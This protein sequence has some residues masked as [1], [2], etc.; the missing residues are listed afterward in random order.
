MMRRTT[1][2][3]LAALA[4]VAPGAAAQ[5][6]ASQSKEPETDGRPLSAW[7][8]DLK[9]D[10]PQVRNA[11][12]YE[13]SGLGPAAV[14]AVPALIEALNDPLEVVRYPVCVALREIGP[15]AKDAVP[16]LTRTLDDRNDDIAAMA[17]KAIIAITGQDP[18]PLE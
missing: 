16:A 18:R 6:T 15:G 9:A 5:T 17:R 7:I 12:A 10:A 8:A 13:I 2:L 14:A 3:A 11:A 4:L 1:L